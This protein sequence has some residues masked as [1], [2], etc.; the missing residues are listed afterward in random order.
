MLNLINIVDIFINDSQIINTLCILLKKVI[1]ILTKEKFQR[2]QINSIN[3]YN[4]DIKVNNLN[5]L[6]NLPNYT[7]RNFY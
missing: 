4:Q 3:K 5:N 1:S 6:T 2:G 7:R